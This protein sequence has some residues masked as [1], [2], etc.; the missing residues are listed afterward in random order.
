MELI[1]FDLGK[2]TTI[3]AQIRSEKGK[4]TKHE[5]IPWCGSA[6]EQVRIESSRWKVGKERESMRKVENNLDLCD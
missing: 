4:L 2:I 1:L 6:I 3:P 5:V